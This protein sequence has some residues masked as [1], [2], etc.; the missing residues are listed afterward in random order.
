[1]RRLLFL[2]I[3]IILSMEMSASKL[4]IKLK[5]DIKYKT[6]VKKQDLYL[7]NVNDIKNSCTPVTKEYFLANE[8][9][10]KVYLKK[11]HILCKKD[12]YKGSKNRLVFKFGMIEIEKDGKLLNQTDDYVR[13]RNDSGKIEKYYKDGR[14]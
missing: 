4:V 13:I 8:Y 7:A 12:I 2:F 11:D 3:F 10:A 1:M 5:K 6:I 9:R 14:R